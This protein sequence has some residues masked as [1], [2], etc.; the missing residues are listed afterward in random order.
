MVDIEHIMQ[1]I[2]HIRTSVPYSRCEFAKIISISPITYHRLLTRNVAYEKTARKLK[3]FI[4]D[5]KNNGRTIS[6]CTE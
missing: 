2:E 6:V 3:K 1:E 5:W 4:E